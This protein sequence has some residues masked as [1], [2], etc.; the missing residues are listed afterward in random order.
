MY[1]QCLDG[2]SFVLCLRLVLRRLEEVRRVVF[3]EPQVGRRGGSA[4]PAGEHRAPPEPRTRPRPESPHQ[5]QRKKGI[6][7]L[8]Y[9]CHSVAEARLS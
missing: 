5:C 2:C 7:G 8:V 6:W 1:L 9:G 4:N 3:T